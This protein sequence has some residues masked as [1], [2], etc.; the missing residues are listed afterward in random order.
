MYICICIFECVSFSFN[1]R[2]HSGLHH[3]FYPSNIRKRRVIFDLLFLLSLTWS[4][5][6]DIQMLE[7]HLPQNNVSF[8]NRFEL[9][10]NVNY[11]G[12]FLR[13]YLFSRKSVMPLGATFTEFWAIFGSNHLVYLPQGQQEASSA[14]IAVFLRSPV[15]YCASAI[16]AES[17]FPSMT[18]R[19]ESGSK[20]DS[21]F[22]IF[23]VSGSTVTRPMPYKLMTCPFPSLPWNFPVNCVSD[24]RWRW[25]AAGHSRHWAAP[26]GSHWWKPHGRGGATPRSRCGDNLKMNHK[27]KLITFM[28]LLFT[29][30]E[31]FS[32]QNCPVP[33]LLQY[34][35]RI[36]KWEGLIGDVKSVF[37]SQSSILIDV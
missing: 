11:Y 29:L 32:Q 3:S 36:D 28:L 34:V 17:I 26:T 25:R 16:S 13:R 8:T 14:S 21:I 4:T 6:Y 5:L 15:R 31:R 20:N 22:P 7:R 24:A 27:T 33:I 12:Y 2:H 23:N 1:Q 35:Y 9:N 37:H 10:W 18:L 19:R 30:K